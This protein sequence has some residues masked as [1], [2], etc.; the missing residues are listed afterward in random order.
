[1]RAEKLT[2]TAACSRLSRRGARLLARRAPLG[3]LALLSIAYLTSATWGLMMRRIFQAHLRTLPLMAVLFLPVLVGA[4]FGEETA[5]Y[6]W[7]QPSAWRRTSW[8]NPARSG[9]P[10]AT[11]ALGGAVSTMRGRMTAT[12][13]VGRGR[14]TG[15]GGPS[16]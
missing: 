11:G 14:A 6:P 1:M 12:L 3:S 4:T 10:A 7:A 13:A 16:R 9:R 15:L 8:A 5:L 2:Q